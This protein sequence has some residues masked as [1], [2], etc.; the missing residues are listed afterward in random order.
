M[1]GVFFIREDGRIVVVGRYFEV[2]LRVIDLMF[3]FGLGSRYIVV[4]GIIKIISVMVISFLESGIIRI[5]KNGLMF[6]E[7]NL[8]LK[9]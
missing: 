3:F 7:Y 2:E 1:D 9:Y 8:R 5:F 4:V 6:F